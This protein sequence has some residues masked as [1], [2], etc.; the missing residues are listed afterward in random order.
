MIFD[1]KEDLVGTSNK[2]NPVTITAN[3]IILEF[4]KKEKIIDKVVYSEE[5]IIEV[6]E[7]LLVLKIGEVDL[8]MIKTKEAKKVADQIRSLIPKN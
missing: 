5:M 3:G 1:Y 4:A 2:E 6:K 8:C 7:D